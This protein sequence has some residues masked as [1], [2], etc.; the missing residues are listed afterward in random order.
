VW[1]WCQDWYGAYPGGPVTDPV[2][3]P[4]G[5][6]RIHRGGSWYGKPRLCRSAGRNWSAPDLGSSDVGFRLARTALPYP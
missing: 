4:S 1:E 6:Y 5:L 3:S 2:G